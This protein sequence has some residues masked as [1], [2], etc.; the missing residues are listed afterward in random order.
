MGFEEP[1]RFK[2]NQDWEKFEEEISAAL[3]KFTS[4]EITQVEQFND[5]DFIVKVINSESL[6]M[7]QKKILATL[8]FEKM[9]YYLS[10]EKS[11][12]FL[13]LKGRCFNLYAHIRDNFTE[14]EFD[15]DVHYKIEYLRAI[16]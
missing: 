15:L 6:T 7:E 10:L 1:T 12:D 14:N 2:K 5:E 8:L 13:K 3:Q 9:N 4:L 16:C 11:E